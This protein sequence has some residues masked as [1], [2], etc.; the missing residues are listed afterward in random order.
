MTIIV[1]TTKYYE[2]VV[3]THVEASAYANPQHAIATYLKDSEL[4]PKP[5]LNDFRFITIK[6]TP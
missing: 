1:S 4:T 2:W 6:G 3:P 5:S